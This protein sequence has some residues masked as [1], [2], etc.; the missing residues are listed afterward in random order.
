M[1]RSGTYSVEILIGD[2][3]LDAPQVWGIAVASIKFGEH[4]L[5][6]QDFVKKSV[7]HDF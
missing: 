7:F 5:N 6:F 1:H 2:V 4:N 3:I